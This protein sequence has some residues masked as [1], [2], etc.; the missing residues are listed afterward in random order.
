MTETQALA[1]FRQFSD[2]FGWA[3]VL[4]TRRDAELA[5][6][7]DLSDD[8]WDQVRNSRSWERDLPDA[9]CFGV[10]AATADAVYTALES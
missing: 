2:E 5:V 8:E 9:L 3:G 6:D 7:R 1:L 4:L 10:H